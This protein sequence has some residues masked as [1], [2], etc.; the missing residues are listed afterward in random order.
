MAV[1][2]RFNGTFQ[3]VHFLNTDTLFTAKMA[4]NGMEGFDILLTRFSSTTLFMHFN[5]VKLAS[6]PHTPHFQLSPWLQSKYVAANV[7]GS[8]P[9]F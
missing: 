9:I 4:L 8:Y 1:T 5:T 3:I 7:S 6:G 2:Y